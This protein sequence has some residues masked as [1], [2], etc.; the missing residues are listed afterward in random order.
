MIFFFFIA[1]K[2]SIVPYGMEMLFKPVYNALPTSY[3][4]Y[5]LEGESLGMPHV[6]I[7]VWAAVVCPVLIGHY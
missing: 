1:S 3:P 2:E 6:D 4:H 7:A 5:I